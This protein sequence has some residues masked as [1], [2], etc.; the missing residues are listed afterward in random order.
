[1]RCIF[2]GFNPEMTNEYYQKNRQ[3]KELN[4]V[5]LQNFGTSM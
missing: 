5:S 4:G 1:M 3:I 2:L